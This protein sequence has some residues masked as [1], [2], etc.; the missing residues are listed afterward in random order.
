MHREKT[1]SQIV[2]LLSDAD[3]ALG[4]AGTL[5]DGVNY[6]EATDTVFNAAP[7][8]LSSGVA[9]AGLVVLGENTG[10]G[11]AEVWYTSDASAMT[12]SNS[13]QIATVNGADR[14]TLDAGDF[15]LKT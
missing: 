1:R 4:A 6:F 7:Q 13:Y 5:T 11:G 9:N 2:H 10:G 3:F 14:S 12:D 8:D 15:N